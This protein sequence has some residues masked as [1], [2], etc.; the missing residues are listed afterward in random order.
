[1]KINMLE[2]LNP[3]NFFLW[4]IISFKDIFNPYKVLN[5]YELINNY[6]KTLKNLG[7]ICLKI[8]SM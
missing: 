4:L 1:M 2:L 6:K 8:L 3:I 5:I 7:I